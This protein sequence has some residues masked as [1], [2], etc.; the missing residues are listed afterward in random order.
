MLLDRALLSVLGSCVFACSYKAPAPRPSRVEAVRSPT[1]NSAHAGPATARVTHSATL[2]QEILGLAAADGTAYVIDRRCSV[3]SFD[4]G[5]LRPLAYQEQK[6]SCRHLASDGD[7]L[8]W[9]GQSA[10]ADRFGGAYSIEALP[11][12]GGEAATVTALS[13]RE[14]DGL[15]WLGSWK[16]GLVWIHDGPHP[17]SESEQIRHIDWARQDGTGR[18]RLADLRHGFSGQVSADASDSLSIVV[19][20]LEG[21]SVRIQSESATVESTL[22]DE[23]KHRALIWADPGADAR[24]IPLGTRGASR[25]LAQAG[26][27]LYFID[28]SDYNLVRQSLSTPKREVLLE[29]SDQLFGVSALSIQGGRVY[30]VE[31]TTSAGLA[32]I[33]QWS[34]GAEPEVLY[35]VKEQNWDITYYLMIANT[36]HVVEN[37]MFTSWTQP[38]K[39][40][41]VRI[42]L[43]NP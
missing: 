18:R 25:V 5:E 40:R 36:V 34:P 37:E 12:A 24:Q 29:S 35:A 11:L 17:A 19:S 42:D 20:S 8:F 16:N 23:S 41:L 39:S 13:H 27:W 28:S 22:V 4:G 7:S 2:G 15:A 32:R 38:R 6:H 21:A 43:A 31:G 3:Y 26:D 30:W 9:R 1:E 14:G 33:W 10:G